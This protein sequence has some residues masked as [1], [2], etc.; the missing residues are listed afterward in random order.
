M[1]FRAKFSISLLLLIAGI[2][3]GFT[4]LIR[5][6]LSKYD[7]RSA[8]SFPLYF[9]KGD[10]SVIFSI[11]KFSKTTSYS[12][13]GGFI[14]KTVSVHYYVQN[15]NTTDGKKLGDK[16]LKRHNDIK[17]YP[18]EILGKSGDTAWIFM[19]EPMAFD[20]FTLAQVADLELLEQKNPSLKGRF[21][22]ERRYFSFNKRDDNI[23]ITATDGTLW[24]LNT[25]TLIAVQ[26]E[27]NNTGTEQE[28]ALE[29]ISKLQDKNRLEQDSLYQ[30]KNYRP[31]RL[32]ADKKITLQEYNRIT[33]TFYEERTLLYKERDSLNALKSKLQ[34]KKQTGDDLKRNIE[35]LERSDNLSLSQI[36]VSGDTLNGQWYGIY[37]AAEMEKLY[38]RFTYQALYGEAERRQLYTSTYLQ[39]KYDNTV[40]AKENTRLQNSASYFLDGGILIDK[41]TARPIWLQ[42]NTSF[43]VVLKDQVGNE[44]NIMLSKVT[45]DGKLNWTFDTKL[46]RWSDWIISD[47]YLFFFGTDNKALSSGETNVFWTID[48]ATGKGIQYDFFK[49]K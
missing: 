22:K 49:D 38:T 15:N 26:Q 29:K 37:S 17:N 28:I 18:I 5:G 32:V 48:L 2:F 7:E 9:K 10:S 1:S 13:N 41:H 42:N 19:G 14:N 3:F 46:K 47:K 30:Q 44:G 39:D 12:Q 25:H 23:Y 16:K 20:P 40:I 31:G 43:L 11:V 8:I 45:V 34:A 35:S 24:Q 21:P 33:K 27:N 6:C 36:K 4:Y